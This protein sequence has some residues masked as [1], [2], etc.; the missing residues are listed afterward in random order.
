MAKRYY[1]AC[2]LTPDIE[3]S[4]LP[5]MVLSASFAETDDYSARMRKWQSAPSVTRL[6]D[7]RLVCAF[8]GDNFGGDEE[9]NNYNILMIS[10]DDGLS[11]KPL[12]VIDHADSVR[13]HE[14]I[15]WCD[16][17]GNL[18][19]FWAQSYKWWD[20]RGGV[21][22]MKASLESDGSITWSKPKRLCDGVMA[23]PPVTL[24]AGEILLPVSIWKRFPSEYHSAP[25]ELQN[26]NVCLFRDGK[27]IYR[28]SAVIDDTTFDENA[29]A[30][31]PDGSLLMTVRCTNSIRACRSYDNG[32]TW[33]E[34]EKVRDHTSSRTF[35]AA[36]PSGNLL[37][38][39]NDDAKER[40]HM[41]A[42]LSEDGGKTWPFS[43]LLKAEG[44]VSYPAG[45]ITPDGRV[46]VA[47]DFNRY[48]DELVFLSS[49]TEEDIKA[50]KIVGKDSFIGRVVSKGE[51]GRDKNKIF[52]DK[53]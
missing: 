47:Y 30:P 22:C 34:P 21:W 16:P 51:N 42:F 4:L 31:C 46:W 23:L 15:V 36:F 9:P 41:T 18:W 17:E 27:A 20:G 25:A 2:D 11:W 5:P 7:G 45:Q 12:N 43:L 39:T 29:L 40:T 44:N 33:S 19:H 13:M 1:T 35:L 26:S 28:G 49:F 48:L 38:V 6:P 52:K 37:M 50:G 24:P 10:S 3:C 14:P 8:S 32:K 53:E